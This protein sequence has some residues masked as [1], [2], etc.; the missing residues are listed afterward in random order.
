VYLVL[1]FS[2]DNFKDKD[3]VARFGVF[4]AVK[5]Q[6]EVFWVVMPFSVVIGYHHFR[7]SCWV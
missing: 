4:M 6:V 7:Y 1:K 5:M 3:F 2:I